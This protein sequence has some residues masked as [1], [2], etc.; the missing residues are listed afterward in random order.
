MRNELKA[1]API[2]MECLA[3]EINECIESIRSYIQIDRQ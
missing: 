3:K 1:I 2:K